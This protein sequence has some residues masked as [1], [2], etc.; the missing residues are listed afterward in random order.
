MSSVAKGDD[1]APLAISITPITALPLPLRG[2]ANRGEPK[3]DN[4]DNIHL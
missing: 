3:D 4:D 2:T 1:P